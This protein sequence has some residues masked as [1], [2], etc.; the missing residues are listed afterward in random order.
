MTRE[1]AI[2]KLRQ[3]SLPKET[4]EIMEAIAPELRESEDERTR[5]RLIEFISAVKI[6]SESGRSTWAVGK[7]DVEMCNAF[8][9]YLEKQ[10]EQK[11]HYCHHEVDET[12]W[13][14]EYRKA[15]YDGWNNCNMQHEQLKADQKPT[16]WS[17]EDDWKRKELIQYLEEKG[18]Y[19][20]VWMTWLKSLCPNKQD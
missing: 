7:D 5:K 8:L 4:M 3:M 10:K 18:D 19:R 14:E 17:E 11:P 6:I 16:E 20:T 12:G 2:N 15:Y 1:E 13:S 9:S